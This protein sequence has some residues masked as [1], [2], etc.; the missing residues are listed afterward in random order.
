MPEF[1]QRINGNGH[2]SEADAAAMADATRPKRDKA[3]AI[4]RP[5]SIDKFY[6]ESQTDEGAK[7]QK[8]AYEA[9]AEKEAAGP[10]RTAAALSY[11]ATKAER[12]GDRQDTLAEAERERFDE[13]LAA[14]GQHCRRRLHSALVYWFVRVLIVLGDVA[15]ASG[16]ILLLGEEPFN[17]FAQ[18]TSVA[19]SAVILGVVGTEV[20]HW[21][22]ANARQ[23]PVEKL[24]EEEKTC[25]SFFTG[26]AP[27]TAIK[28]LG[29]VFIAGVAA[30]VGGIFT[31]REAAEGQDVAVAFGCFAFAVCVAS[32]LNS[33]EYACEV[34]DYLE[35][36]NSWRK[37]FGKEAAE[38]GAAP[39][40]SEHHAAE[41]EVESIKARNKAESAA[42]GHGLR[43]EM[44]EEFQ[45]EPKTFGHGTARREARESK[46]G[47]GGR[48]TAGG[49]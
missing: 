8:E 23:K 6:A 39:V 30:I 2:R 17:A 34:S 24:N 11:Q 32:F 33:Y 42:A 27:F 49:S 40:I 35:T 25:E 21:V 14:L 3:H 31:L 44:Y 26:P 16:A 38:A 29:L 48:G 18:A 10:A 7:E 1:T 36:A 19:V 43:R 15:G 5:D 28:I 45:R 22:A 20:R 4:S 12:A 9:N 41:A 13:R 47:R 37:K 46:G